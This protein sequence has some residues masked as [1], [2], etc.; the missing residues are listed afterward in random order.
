[1]FAV[2]LVVT[3]IVFIATAGCGKLTLTLPETSSIL[4]FLK[5]E[6]LVGGSNLADGSAELI[7]LIHLKN[8][9]NT[10]VPNYRP[11]YLVTSS[12]GITAGDCSLSSSE[13]VSV[14]VLKSTS[15]GTKLMKLT[16]AL[17]GLEKAIEFVA[18]AGGQIFGLASG[19]KKNMTTAAGHKINLSVGEGPKPQ[20]SVTSG[21]YKVLSG[22]G[23]AADS[24]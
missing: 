7:V 23:L 8:S 9:D 15:P 24:M 19:A 11:T 12:A 21:G 13:G 17:K 18:P 14:C 6:I 5:T 1:M 16:N 3:V 2:R 22:V 20:K 10:V 4:D